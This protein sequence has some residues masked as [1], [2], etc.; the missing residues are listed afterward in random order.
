MGRL[1]SSQDKGEGAQE[2]KAKR[3]AEEAI[4]AVTGDK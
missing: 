2:G 1:N 3:K 4:G